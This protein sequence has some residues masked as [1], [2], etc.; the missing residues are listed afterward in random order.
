ME[1]SIMPRTGDVRHA[2]HTSLLGVRLL[3]LGL[4]GRGGVVGV[5]L[6][7]ITIHQDVKERSVGLFTLIGRVAVICT[8]LALGMGK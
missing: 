5:A 7:V 6:D 3:G 4:T 8:R 2:Q 1:I